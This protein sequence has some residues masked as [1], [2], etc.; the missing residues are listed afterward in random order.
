MPT[1]PKRENC[2]FFCIGMGAIL[3]YSYIIYTHAINMPKWDDF[4]D[5]LQFMDRW[6]EA[7][8]LAEKF[9]VFL[10]HTN[11]H[12]LLVN[13]VIILS[14]YYLMGHLDFRWLIY[15]GNLFYI[16][17]AFLLWLPFKNKEE[18]ALAFAVLMLTAVTFYAYEST[19]WA[20]TA[21]SNQAVIFF[22][23][24]TLWYATQAT[25]AMSRL[26]PLTTLAIFSQSNGFFILPLIGVLL[27]FSDRKKL[28]PWLIFSILI[29]TIYLVLLNPASHQNPQLEWSDI[30]LKNYLVT[31]PAFVA[32]FGSAIFNEATIFTFMISIFLGLIIL[33][34]VFKQMAKHHY[35]L[36]VVYALIFFVLCMAS[37]ALYRGLAGP[38]VIFISRYKMYSIY[39]LAL[40]LLLNPQ[41]LTLCKAYPWRRYSLLLF[42]VLFFSASF[43]LNL[44]KSTLIDGHLRESLEYWV[45]DGDFRR[46]KG[47]FVHDS[48]SYLFAA[49]HR[50]IWSPLSLIQ[51]ERIIRDITSLD[52]CPDDSN[53]LPAETIAPF[54]I[55]HINRN[56]PG[57][58]MEFSPDMALNKNEQ[59]VYLCSQNHHY[60]LRFTVQQ[61]SMGSYPPYYIPAAQIAPGTYN[62]YIEDHGILRLTN[63]NLLRKPHTR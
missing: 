28:T 9:S 2:F 50:N 34:V 20:M 61:K 45:E 16:G 63:Q 41:W 53:T 12:I 49:L 30:P 8:S 37:I 48:D 55:K 38:S 36:F 35:P 1:N 31:L 7:N 40:G 32:I 29:I 19:L 57:I 51:P 5:I 10:Y 62:I 58:R 17:S 3:F 44:P 11:E 4:P 23:L 27:F 43:Y 14:Q 56:A 54:Q 25:V 26:I 24:L 33:L 46:G 15:I 47:Y 13:H 6:L 22:S 21:L 59:R 52:T 18:S 42:C 39:F 60:R